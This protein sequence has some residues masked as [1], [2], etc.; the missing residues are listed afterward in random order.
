MPASFGPRIALCSNCT[1]KSFQTTK[2]HPNSNGLA[3]NPN[4]T[5]FKFK[6]FKNL[7]G[8]Q[9]MG[10]K[11]QAPYLQ[12]MRSRAWL[13]PRRRPRCWRGHAKALTRR[14]HTTS[15]VVFADDGAAGSRHWSEKVRV[16]RD[17]GSWS[18]ERR[19]FW[20][21]ERDF[22]WEDFSGEREWERDN[23]RMSWGAAGIEDSQPRMPRGV[24]RFKILSN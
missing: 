22:G 11:L 6:L 4:P 12:E 21:R 15:Q 2:F 18:F 3:S 20:V 19:E 9:I 7:K 24:W 16:W 5:K 8:L 14:T 17:L 10:K 23:E 13:R 1:P